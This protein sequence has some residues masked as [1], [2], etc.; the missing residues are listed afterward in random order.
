MTEMTIRARPAS[1]VMYGVVYLAFVSVL[2]T[3][4]VSSVYVRYFYSIYLQL[5]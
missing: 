3:D 4:I 1:C 5:Q 2:N